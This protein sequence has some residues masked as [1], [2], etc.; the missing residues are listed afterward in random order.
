MDHGLP[1]VHSKYFHLLGHVAGS[2]S[3]YTK[4]LTPSN[5]FYQNRD[6]A[7]KW[8]VSLEQGLSTNDNELDASAIVLSEY[9]GKGCSLGPRGRLE[10][11]N[12]QWDLIVVLV[13][14]RQKRNLETNTVSSHGS[15]TCPFLVSWDGPWVAI[16]SFFVKAVYERLLWQGLLPTWLWWGTWLKTGIRLQSC[17]GNRYTGLTEWASSSLRYGMKAW[18]LR[19]LAANPGHAWGH[20]KAD[21]NPRDWGMRISDPR[22]LSVFPPSVSSSRWSSAALPRFLQFFSSTV[23]LCES[24]WQVLFFFF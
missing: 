3:L 24:F 2:P 16:V 9:L 21:W 1:G 19:S 13:F 4:L 22:S 14:T 12:G 18:V 17:L 5:A 7:W 23:S 6:W 10:A 20:P 11:I 8:T 15:Y